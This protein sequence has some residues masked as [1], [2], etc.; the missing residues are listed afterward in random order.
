[1]GAPGDEYGWQSGSMK[2]LIFG[3][4]GQD[5]SYLAELLLARGYRVAGWVPEHIPFSQ[6]NLAPFA[7]RI[8]LLH[9][10]L[11]SQES[12][13]AC[14]EETRP[15]EIYNLA[16]PSFPAGSWESTVLVGDVAGLGVA[17]ILEAVR[18]IVPHA[19]FYQASSSEIFGSPI[20]S[21]QNES[22]P[23]HPRNPYGIAKLYAHWITVRYREYYGLFTTSGILFNHESPRRGVQF[24]TRKI[25]MR[26]VEIKLGLTDSLKLGDLEARRDWGFAGDYVEAMWRMM[27][28][29]SPDSYVI[30]TGIPHSVREFCE[31]AFACVN[32]DYRDYVVKDPEL[33]RPPEQAQLVADAS[34]AQ[35]ELDWQPKVSFEELVRMMVRA[36]YQ[37]V[38]GAP[39]PNS[40]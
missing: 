2:A 29:P 30:G 17:R 6:S 22:T 20:Q 35:R 15:D 16:A 34:K 38:S 25:T 24:V 7:D 10:D 14:L 13:N 9:G 12:I 32:L 11:F 1:V 37:A 8:R 26:A 19:H 39:Y 40:G 18:K 23:F 36:D 31:L 27:Q 21:P 33:V 5:G 3:I 28:A 4:D